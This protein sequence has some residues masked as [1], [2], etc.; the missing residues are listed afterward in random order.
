MDFDTV[1]FQKEDHIAVITMNRPE[2]M[3]AINN[4]FIKELNQIFDEIEDDPETGAVIITGTGKTFAAGAD[5]KEVQ[6]IG[7]PADAHDFVSKIQALFCRIENLEKPVIA[8]VNGLALGGGCEITLACDLRIA[9]EN[10]LFGLPEIKIGVLPVAGGT[11]RLPRL[12]GVGRA[13]EMLFT[14]DPIDAAEAYRIGLANRVV[15][16]DSLMDEA[17]KL[18]ADLMK[19]PGHAFK[20]IKGCVNRGINMDLDSALAYEGRCFEILFSTDDQKEGME[21]FVEKRKPVF[22]NR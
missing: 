9:A 13:K 20:M 11:Q 8:A 6:G 7:S 14:G 19:R 1:V 2:S 5:I 17:K 22:K 16:L 21:A 3:N 10:A 12:V 15:P 4:K 18:A